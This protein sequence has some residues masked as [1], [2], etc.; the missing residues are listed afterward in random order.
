MG[1]PLSEFYDMTEYEFSIIRAGYQKRQIVEWERTRFVAW[2][3]QATQASKPLSVEEIMP[4]PIDA[5]RKA[6][7][8]KLKKSVKVS[9]KKF[10]NISSR[11]GLK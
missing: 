4:L 6:Q 9:T 5:E 3:I 1:I 11:L 8:D 2:M 7:R 10:D